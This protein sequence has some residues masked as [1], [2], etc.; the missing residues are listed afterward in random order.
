MR[1]ILRSAGLGALGLMLL[2]MGVGFASAANLPAGP[3]V[4][5]SHLTTDRR[6][7]PKE[8][9][10]SLSRLERSGH[11]LARYAS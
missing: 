6:G 2:A 3:L 7:L 8:I 11:G 1:G 4:A 9:E 5:S 10:T